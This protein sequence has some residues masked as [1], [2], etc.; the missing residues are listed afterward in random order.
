MREIYLQARALLARQLGPVREEELLPGTPFQ[1]LQADSIDILEVIMA[2]EDLYA[3]EF[4]EFQLEEC[5]NLGDLAG[6]VENYLKSVG[7]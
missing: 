3:V 4:P 5:R 6:A 1:D 2:L 7:K